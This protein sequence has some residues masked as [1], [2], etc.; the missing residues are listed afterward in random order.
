MR[1]KVIAFKG[2][3]IQTR[4]D[5]NESIGDCTVD[6]RGEIDPLDCESQE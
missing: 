5:V 6:P 3:R 2:W 4:D 1:Y